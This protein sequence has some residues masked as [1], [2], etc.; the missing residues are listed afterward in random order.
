[1]GNKSTPIALRVGWFQPHQALWHTNKK[2]F[3]NILSED[4]KIRE[5][6]SKKFHSAVISDLTIGRTTNAIELK[7]TCQRPSVIVGKKGAEIEI[8]TSE[9]QKMTGKEI[10]LRVLEI[11]KPEISAHVIA[12]EM[13]IELKK[14]GASPKRVMKKLVQQARKFGAL[15]IRIECKGRLAGA[16][17]ARTEWHQEGAVP[18]QKFRANINYATE[19][20][21]AAWGDSGVKVWVYLGDTLDPKNLFDNKAL[22]EEKG[23]RS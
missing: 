14:R 23:E 6:V 15:G 16:E 3:A 17:I 13:A 12:R 18:R 2:M 5:H 21:H 9:L 11:K 7:I 22:F 1:M 19:T 10:K 20:S 8:F 4:M